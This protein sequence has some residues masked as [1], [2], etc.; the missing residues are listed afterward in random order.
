MW[1]RISCFNSSI[2]IF[3]LHQLKFFSKM[4]SLIFLLTLLF[5]ESIA[6]ESGLYLLTDNSF[7]KMDPQ[8]GIFTKI[9]ST[10]GIPV[11]VTRSLA[12][13]PKVKIRSLF[14]F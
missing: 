3:S 10:P 2:V 7:G 8:S 14:T 13:D 11:P 4:N 5:C 6:S 9:V 1:Y 12:Y